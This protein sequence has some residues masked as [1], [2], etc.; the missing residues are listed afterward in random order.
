MKIIMTNLFKIDLALEQC[1]EEFFSDK[2][3][4]Q[5]YLEDLLTTIVSSSGDREYEFDDQ[6]NSQRAKRDLAVAYSA[7][8]GAPASKGIRVY[9]EK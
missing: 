7:H 9:E 5:K 1:K 2:Q 8:K 6:Q 3:N 4:I